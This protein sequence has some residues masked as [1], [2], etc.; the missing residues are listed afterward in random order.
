MVML[1]LF[2]ITIENYPQ[3][4]HLKTQEPHAIVNDYIID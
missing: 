1:V 3:V 2:H 4:I